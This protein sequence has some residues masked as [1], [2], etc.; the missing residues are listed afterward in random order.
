MRVILGNL[1]QKSAFSSVLTHHLPLKVSVLGKKKKYAQHKIIIQKKREGIKKQFSILDYSKACQL[2]CCWTFSFF[3]EKQTPICIC[4]SEEDSKMQQS[5]G[6]NSN[7]QKTEWL[8]VRARVAALC[9]VKSNCMK[10]R[11]SVISNDTHLSCLLCAALVPPASWSM[12]AWTRRRSACWPSTTQRA[13]LC[14]AWSTPLASCSP[15]CRTGRWW[16]MEGITAVRF[17]RVD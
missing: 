5:S 17:S 14:C 9:T 6:G 11:H 1:N 13:A 16:F 12:G 15:A 3:A 8:L 4:H 7:M 2:Q 10:T